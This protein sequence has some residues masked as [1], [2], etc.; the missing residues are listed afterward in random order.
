MVRTAAPNHA[1]KVSRGADPPSWL[2]FIEY[3]ANYNPPFDGGCWHR[4]WC[5]AALACKEV[6]DAL[7][8]V[9]AESSVPA[10]IHLYNQ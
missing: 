5:V 7:Y 2:S 8:R 9:S 1:H 6:V 4:S 3:L 10:E